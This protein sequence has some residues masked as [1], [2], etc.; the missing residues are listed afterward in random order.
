MSF[1]LI[2]FDREFQNEH[3]RNALRVFTNENRR[4]CFSKKINNTKTYHFQQGSDQDPFYENEE[5]IVCATGNIYAIENKL[6]KNVDLGKSLLEYITKKGGNFIPDIDGEFTLFIYSKILN[7]YYIYNDCFGF[8]PL[9]YYCNSD[10]IVLCN[11]IEPVI[12]FLKENIQFNND[13]LAEHFCLDHTVGN[14]TFYKGIFNL[15]AGTK[16]VI[17]NG[18]SFQCKQY[19][20][21]QI[22]SIKNPEINEIAE[23]IANLLKQAIQKRM[24]SSDKNTFTLTGG[25]DTRMITECIDRNLLNTQRFVTYKATNLSEETDQDVVIAGEIAKKSRLNFSILDYSFFDEE[26]DTH[27][28][29][30]RRESISEKYFSGVFGSELIRCEIKHAL[31]PDYYNYLISLEK[32]YSLRHITYL[33][34]R[35]A[36]IQ[37]TDSKMSLFSDDFI[38][39]I[40]HPIFSIEREYF[41][42]ENYSNKLLRYFITLMTRSFYLNIYGGT[43][44]Y[45]MER[46]CNILFSYKT[47]F[48]DRNL[49]LFLLSIPYKFYCENIVEIY[50]VL[51][52]KHYTTYLD[53][54]TNSSFTSNADFKIGKIKTGINQID[55]RYYKC[56]LIIDYAKHNDS[57]LDLVFSQPISTLIC[58]SDANLKQKI[59]DFTLWSKYIKKH[60]ID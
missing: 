59:I 21:S 54:L 15:P 24:F 10:N 41:S 49:L 13:V 60:I 8:Y 3:S 28:Y 6:V 2:I 7:E 43:R 52:T 33:Q 35:K 31:D 18:F 25:L 5:Y 45:L 4:K 34:K 12:S 16:L 36:F 46:P 30:K 32:K 47:P 38:K 57:Y 29:K 56:K 11:E 27:Y 39:T 22:I 23:Q 42:E 44:A 50:N 48:L 37:K 51:F 19:E 55:T 26:M 1:L 17:D 20:I 9:Y 58:D 40:E 14:K 53:V